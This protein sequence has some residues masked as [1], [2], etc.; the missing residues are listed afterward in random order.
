MCAVFVTNNENTNNQSYVHT[1]I[2]SY[3]VKPQ[4]KMDVEELIIN[5][6]QSILVHP[7]LFLHILIY[8]QHIHIHN[9]FH[10]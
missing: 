3:V 5:L 8:T 10:L 4:L 2:R 7:A 6:R 1:R 9:I